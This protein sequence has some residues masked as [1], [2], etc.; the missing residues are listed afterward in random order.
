FCCCDDLLLL[1]FPALLLSVYRDNLKY[2]VI[3]RSCLLFHLISAMWMP[4]NKRV[5]FVSNGLLRQTEKD[6]I[7]MM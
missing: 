5:I 3:Y 6:V 2:Q 1:L 4:V 7:F